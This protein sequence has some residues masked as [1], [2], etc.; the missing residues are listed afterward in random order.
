MTLATACPKPAKKLRERPR[1]LPRSTKPIKR[2]EL[3]RGTKPIPQV[4]V[5]RQRRRNKEYAAHLRS[6]YWQ[7]I[8]RQAYDRDGGLCWCPTCVEGRK[9]G[10]AFAF[11]PVPVWFD[12]KG[13]IHG[14]DTHHVT[15]LR[16]GQELLSDVLTMH[17]D[18]HR[19]LEALT[20]KRS[21]F[22]RGK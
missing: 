9:N 11:E 18:H 19:K 1:W 5:K 22:L 14:F 13:R 17:R 7:Q 15:Y 21:R 16:F 3:K 10:E 12:L 6:A 8:R 2:S 4:N 20:G